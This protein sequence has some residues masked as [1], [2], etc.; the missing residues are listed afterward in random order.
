[1]VKTALIAD[2]YFALDNTLIQTRWGDKLFCEKVLQ[3][4]Y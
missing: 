1:M 4:A 3:N 2:V